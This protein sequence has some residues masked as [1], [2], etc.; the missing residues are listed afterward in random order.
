MSVFISYS[1]QDRTIAGQIAASLAHH[2]IT[3]WWDRSLSPGIAYMDKI[4][5]EIAQSRYVV[6]IWTP[7]SVASK[8]VFAEALLGR[9][10]L[11]PV[12]IGATEIPQEFANLHHHAVGPKGENI[13]E[14]VD[15]AVRLLM[16]LANY[17]LVVDDD[18]ITRR[19]VTKILIDDL[20][21]EA[22]SVDTPEAALDVVSS[23]PPALIIVDEDFG[24]L[25]STQ[26]TDFIK[27]LRKRESLSEMQIISLTSMS[28]APTESRL[29]EAGADDFVSKPID[30]T[31]FVS[32]VRKS[33]G[34]RLSA[35]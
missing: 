1:S 10:K 3:V 26:G 33:W 16:P 34:R 35:M 11:L 6:P 31:S 22:Q 23:K 20:G 29:L 4:V 21:L 32:R 19:L 17:V 27:L 2:R 18:P 8:W 15:H 14:F 24:N 12:R 13:Q 28:G 25:S 5:D 7:S 9:H 30:R